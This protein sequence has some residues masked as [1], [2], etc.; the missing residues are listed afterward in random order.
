MH[1]GTRI[2]LLKHDSTKI[3]TDHLGSEL[4]RWVTKYAPKAYDLSFIPLQALID[5][6]SK[7][8]LLFSMGEHGL[9]QL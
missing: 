1:R 8:G 9:T 7:Q 4:V 5:S 2:D 3:N 6:L